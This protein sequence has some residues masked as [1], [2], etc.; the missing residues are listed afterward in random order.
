MKSMKTKVVLES[1]DFHCMYKSSCNIPQNIFF[2]FPQKKESQTVF[3]NSKFCQNFPFWVNYPLNVYSVF[4][5]YITLCLSGSSVSNWGF[6]PLCT[7]MN[8]TISEA[9]GGGLGSSNSPIAHRPIWCPHIARLS[10]RL[11]LTGNVLVIHRYSV[12]QFVFVI[13]LLLLP[14]PAG[15]TSGS[16]QR[17]LSLTPPPTLSFL[18][19]IST[20]MTTIELFKKCYQEK[21]EK[22]RLYF[23]APTR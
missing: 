21:R 1:I 13:C 4:T 15:L 3:E 18:W 2:C 14:S 7:L 22:N 8:F 16:P 10:C 23:S 19:V 17:R 5:E 20:C 9:S 11:V 6:S 12:W